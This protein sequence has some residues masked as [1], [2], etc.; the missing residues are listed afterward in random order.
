MKKYVKLYLQIESCEPSEDNHQDFNVGM[1]A[2]RISREIREIVSKYNFRIS[3]ERVDSY[4][5]S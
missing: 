3:N 2:G 5:E 4:E 1:A